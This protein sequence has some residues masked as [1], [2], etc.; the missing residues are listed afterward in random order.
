M[1]NEAGFRMKPAGPPAARMPGKRLQSGPSP[2]LSVTKLLMD[3]TF[4]RILLTLIS[5]VRSFVAWQLL[6]GRNIVSLAVTAERAL[7]RTAGWLSAPPK[8]RFLRHL[9]FSLRDVRRW[10]LAA[11]EHPFL[12]AFNLLRSPRLSAAPAAG[13]LY[14]A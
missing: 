13:A 9:S 8:T 5:P 6:C 4:V 12:I 1:F 14:I 10:H 11:G 7:L 3:V 2:R